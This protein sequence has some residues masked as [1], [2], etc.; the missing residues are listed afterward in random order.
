MPLLERILPNLFLRRFVLEQVPKGSVC[1][2]IGIH[3]GDFSAFILKAVQPRE[4][5]LIDPWKFETGDEYKHSLYGR[6]FGRG[7]AQLDNRYN[8]VK[9]RFARQVEE[10]IVVVHRLPSAEA[11]AQFPEGYL[12]WIYIDG[13]HLYPFVKADLEGYA[14]KLKSGGFLAGDDYGVAG[15]WRDGVT[16]AV[17]EFAA[18]HPSVQLSARNGQYLLKQS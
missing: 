2:E 17:D 3:K 11:A 5:H 1:A 14:P 13:N 4:L 8:F 10:G 9:K 12:D 15:W 18:T 7:Q 6:M 16:K